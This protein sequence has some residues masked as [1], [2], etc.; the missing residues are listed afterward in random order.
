MRRPVILN[1][2]DNLWLMRTYVLIFIHRCSASHSLHTHTHTVIHMHAR[3]TIIY[4]YI[5]IVYITGRAVYAF[6][7]RSIVIAAA[8]VYAYVFTGFYSRSFCFLNTYIYFLPLLLVVLD[9]CSL[10]DFDY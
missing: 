7:A 1:T 2:H 9:G 6:I 5:I 10:F 3:K 4:I 8:F